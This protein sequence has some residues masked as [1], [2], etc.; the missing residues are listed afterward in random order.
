MQREGIDLTYILP[1]RSATA[2]VDGE[3]TGYLRWLSE[4]AEIIVVD[5]SD[6]NVFQLH[7]EQWGRYA[8][9]VAPKSSL[10]TQMGKVGGV[11]TGLALASH[12]RVVIADDDIRYDADALRRVSEALD[13]AEVVRP[14]NYF[15][16]MTWHAWWDTGRTLLNRAADGD[17]P[18][19]LAVR[20][21]SLRRTD[22]YDGSTMFE[23]LELVR[24]VIASGGRE[25]VLLDAYVARHPCTTRH[26]WSQRVRQAYDEF[27]RPK[28]L[29]LQLAL[30][31]AAVGV[32]ALGGAP[33]GAAAIAATIAVAEYGRRRAGGAKIFPA[34]TSL[35]APL[36]LVERSIGSWLAIASQVLFGGVRYRGR[37]L[38]HAATPMRVLRDRYSAL[39]EP[40]KSAA[41]PKPAA[42]HR[43]A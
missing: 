38:P 18:G 27:A 26:F 8:I 29:G 30:L 23:N 43:S 14:Q 19:T 9:H 21:D 20:R 31:P 37:V 42:P 36:W 34:H 5:G 25:A 41:Q 12:E 13:D 16:T 28:R 17:W 10:A 32:V 24:T 39:R 7:E 11:L 33:A 40:A 2:L 4:R 1:L 3:L 6:L 35:A 22:G 15:V